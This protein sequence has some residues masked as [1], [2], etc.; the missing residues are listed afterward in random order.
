[1]R[2]EKNHS[3]KYDNDDDV[4]ETII[5]YKWKC[6]RICV[7]YTQIQLW[8]WC[9]MRYSSLSK[10]KFRQFFFVVWFHLLIDSSRR[11]S[12]NTLINKMKTRW[13]WVRG[14]RYMQVGNDWKFIFFAIIFAYS[15]FCE[16]FNKNTV[17]N[18]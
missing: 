10:I 14:A 3:G 11:Q 12:I 2:L 1:M 16:S 9:D 13:L 15:L 17:F 8:L 6:V 18:K 7:H 4:V 5:I